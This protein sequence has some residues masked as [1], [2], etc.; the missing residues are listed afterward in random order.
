MMTWFCRT[1]V[2]AIFFTF[3]GTMSA[4]PQVNPPQEETYDT[5]TRANLRFSVNDIT[6]IET[7]KPALED[8]FSASHFTALKGITTFR[9]GPYRD[10]ATAGAIE[11]RPVS[12][13]VKWVFHT[14]PQGKWGGGAG[15]T[16]QPAVVQW[17]DSI[18]ALM[19][20]KSEYATQSDFTEVVFGSLDGNIYFLDLNTGRPSRNPIDIKNPIKGT[21]TIDP[22]GY[23]MLY[24][25]QG[26]A[27]QEEFG[28]RIFSLIDQKLLYYINGHDAYALR[29]WAAFD[30]AA[31]INPKNDRMYLGGENGILYSLKLNSRL[32]VPAKTM[33]IHPQVLKYRYEVN[34]EHHQG[35]ENSVTAYRDHVYFADNHGYIQSL[36]LTTLTPG[37]IFFNH[38]DT[39]ATLV[40]EPEGQVPFLYTGCEVDK[41]G[42]HGAA[43]LKK[44]NGTTGGTVWERKFECFTVRGKEPVNG[45]LL[46]TPII[47]KGKSSHQ[48][49][50]CLS[51]YGGMSTGLLVALDKNTG[52]TDYE[53][54]L[55]SYAWSSPVDIYD[56]AGNMYIFLADSHG[57]VMLFDGADGAMI[58]QAKI[59]DL[60]EASP[61]VFDNKIIIPSRPDK[62][63]CLEI[64]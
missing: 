63:F 6:G 42:D 32:D 24:C 31:L 33:S 34:R 48:V 16:G 35:I 39:D 19:N 21:V 57:R 15:W 22:R 9:G 51:R 45:G 5:L 64:R 58:Y 56:A 11:K 40:L 52:K 54:K 3:G 62:I 61:V 28:F 1:V 49:I 38:D 8:S 37:W 50:F 17:P 43:Y 4:M 44:I 10:R 41:Q 53:V 14:R 12:L 2:P 59:A 55:N 29:S 25:G 27:N 60:F 36:D 7:F 13:S 30:G 26:I 23:P 18:R 47:G 20:L 46:S